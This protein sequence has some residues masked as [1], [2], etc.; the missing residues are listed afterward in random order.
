LAEPRQV[1]EVMASREL[2]QGTLLETA[3]LIRALDLIVTIDSGIAHLAGALGK[4]V[5]VALSTA[6]DWRWLTV[7]PDSPW[8][9]TMR[10]FRQSRPGQWTD[11]F[12]AIRSELEIFMRQIRPI[13]RT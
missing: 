5:W 2:G 1:L 12:E 3:A 6:S 10:L 9:P 7:R 13:A 4:P 8:Y 11:V